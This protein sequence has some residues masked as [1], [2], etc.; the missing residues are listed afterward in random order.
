MKKLKETNDTKTGPQLTDDELEEALTAS[1]NSM[2]DI[3]E[4]IEDTEKIVNDKNLNIK[5]PGFK[6]VLNIEDMIVRHL[7]DKEMK[8]EILATTISEEATLS[9]TK[10]K[11]KSNK[12]VLDN[13]I[14]KEIKMA[15]ESLKQIIA[16][17]ITGDSGGPM[18]MN[19][20]GKY[21]VLGVVSFSYGCA[22]P[23]KPG[24]YTRVARFDKWIQNTMR[25]N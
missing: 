21:T 18:V 23:D 20:G 19:V 2:S 16:P 10:H 14:F 9:I 5:L 8:K 13:D 12:I 7:N 17:L 4:L 24:V 3:E 15:S 11:E 6:T 25:N 22:R 1:N